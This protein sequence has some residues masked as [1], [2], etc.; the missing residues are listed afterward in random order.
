[1]KKAL[2]SM[3]MI[4][5]CLGVANAQLMV[6]SDGNVGA[7]IDATGLQSYFTVNSVGNAES[8]AFIQA[9]ANE[10]RIGLYVRSFGDNPEKFAFQVAGQFSA[11]VHANQSSMGIHARASKSTPIN[12]GRSFGVLGYAGNATNGYNYGIFGCLNG[13][14]NGAGVYGSITSEDSGTDTGGRYAGYFNGPV[15]VTSTLTAQS[16]VN[17]SDYRVK[18][19][20]RS[21]SNSSLG[22][23]MSMNVVEYNYDA[24]VLMPADDSDTSS[25][26][27]RSLQL[28]KEKSLIAA[29]KHYGLIAQ[30]LQQL[31][32][33]LV[34]ESQD[35]YLTIN[36]IEI[37][38]LLIRSV[39]EL[40]AKIE[41]YEQGDVPIQKAQSRTTDVTGIDAVVTALYQNEPN[42]FTESTIIRVD[43]A[44]GI[45]TA[46][47]YIYNMNGEQITEYPIIERGATNVTIDGGSLGVGMY[48]YA[49][50][51]DGQVIDTKRM[52]LTK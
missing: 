9:N 28:S 32:P 36:Y 19:N 29:E 4:A 43:V 26:V 22:N 20:I 30:E 38:P 44:E 1:M 47:L 42:P 2:L 10:H 52:I 46:N 35:G 3:L 50:I 40:N 37:I 23:I 17:L 39:Q 31:Y 18:K 8:T 11:E 51:A 6:D 21:L 14:N 48:L 25:V 24:D 34:K 27:T 45:T 13:T 15:K 49:L 16:I 41:Q 33:D 5:S 7:Y 12:S